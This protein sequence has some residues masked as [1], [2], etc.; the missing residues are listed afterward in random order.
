MQLDNFIRIPSAQ[1]E[2]MHACC[3]NCPTWQPNFSR[4]ASTGGQQNLFHQ[5]PP[6]DKRTAF[7]KFELSNRGVDPPG[8]HGR[9]C[10]AFFFRGWSLPNALGLGMAV[11]HRDSGSLKL[12]PAFFCTREFACEACKCWLGIASGFLEEHLGHA[13]MTWSG[14]GYDDKKR[15]SQI[16][17]LDYFNVCFCCPILVL[18]AMLLVCFTPFCRMKFLAFVF[19]NGKPMSAAPWHAV[20]QFACA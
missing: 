18:A 13:A 2:K 12:N 16:V 7:N 5:D 4:S 3:C 20:S 14:L 17:T 1:S 19:P 6:I 10:P 8:W 15:L 9:P 11:A